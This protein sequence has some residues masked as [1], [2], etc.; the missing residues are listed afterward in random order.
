MSI[1][2]VGPIKNT[3]FCF[4]RGMFGMFSASQ[5]LGKGCTICTKSMVRDKINLKLWMH[6][7]LK[8]KEVVLSAACELPLLL[9]AGNVQ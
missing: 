7:F 5:P 8:E 4:F 1:R 2:A 6:K 3:L 9:N